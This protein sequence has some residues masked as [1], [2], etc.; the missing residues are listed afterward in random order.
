ML[1][2]LPT[3]L[4]V[5]GRTYAIR[6][7]FRD[8]LP[9]F[10]AF[11][12]PE[13]SDQEKTYVFLRRLFVD[14][15]AIP[16]RDYAEAYKAASA[17]VSVGAQED[18]PG[19]QLVDWE[20]DE[21]MIFPAINKVAGQEVRSIPYM[22]WWTFMGYFQCIDRDDLWGFVLSIRQKRAKHKKLEKY[23]REFV[24]ANPRLFKASSPQSR[25]S[26]DDPLAAMFEA[27]TK[28]GKA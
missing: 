28:G 1:G 7:D 11:S 12:D 19:P 16:R 21:Q 5:C 3:T 23:E 22:H 15:D 25:Q 2:K 18:K 8:I 6:T 4:D 27:L 10:A 14:F 9:T 20:R 13:L 26:A 17:F 24:N